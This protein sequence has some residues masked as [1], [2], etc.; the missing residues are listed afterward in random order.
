MAR[1]DGARDFCAVAIQHAQQDVVAGVEVKAF[2]GDR[3]KRVLDLR[4]LAESARVEPVEQQR[5]EGAGPDQSPVGGHRDHAAALVAHHQDADR[6][7][8]DR[9]DDEDPRHEDAVQLAHLSHR[10]PPRCRRWGR[11]DARPG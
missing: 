11:Q 7:R 2:V 8:H 4:P 1:I 5:P 9:G 3:A 6:D 10:Q